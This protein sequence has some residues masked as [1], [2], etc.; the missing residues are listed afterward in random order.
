M[1]ARIPGAPTWFDPFLLWYLRSRGGAPD[2]WCTCD[3]VSI[4]TCWPAFGT[5]S[6]KDMRW[7]R[8]KGR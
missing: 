5:L 4:D 3:Q 6:R 1:K 2:C 7:D 8:K